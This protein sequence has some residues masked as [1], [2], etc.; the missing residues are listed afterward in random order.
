M[1]NVSLYII[2]SLLLTLFVNCKPGVPSRVI[3][4]SDME[5]ILYDYHIAQAMAEAERDSINFKRYSY[6]NSVFEKHGITEAEFDSSMIWYST[7][8]TYLQTIYKSIKERYTASVAALGAAVGGND[9]F[10]NLEQAGDTAN[11]WHERAFKTLRTRPTE[12][13]MT[14]LLTAD[15]TFRKGDSFLWDFNMVYVS[16]SKKRNEVYVALYVKYDNDSVIGTTQRVYSNTKI[17]MKL[18]CDKTNVIKQIGGFVYYKKKTNDDAFNL[19]I[20]DDIKLIRIHTQPKEVKQQIKADSLQTD[21][22]V[23]DTLLPVHDDTIE[24]VSVKR[25][26]PDEFRQTQKV[27]KSIN[28]VK[29]K[30]YTVSS[31]RKIKRK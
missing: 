26:S 17:R 27:E 1:K 15:T 3:S 21:S 31:K 6:V 22:I 9:A 8:A 5:E 30:P 11:I 14:F 10:S 25:M 24:N 19:L 7:H 23:R 16:Q 28:V 2:L 18:E 12:D 20:M 13:K 29:E 4:P